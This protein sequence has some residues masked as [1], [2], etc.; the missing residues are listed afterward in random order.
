MCVVSTY[1]L[2]WETGVSICRYLKL[3]QHRKLFLKKVVPKSTLNIKLPANFEP[4]AALGWAR[5]DIEI[6]I[7]DRDLVFI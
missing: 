2:R 5:I 6:Q 3:K 4:N 1:L 7:A